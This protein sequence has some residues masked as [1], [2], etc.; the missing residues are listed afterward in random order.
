MSVRKKTY[1]FLALVV[2][3]ALTGYLALPY[4]SSGGA[5]SSADT[6]KEEAKKKEESSIPV[7]IAIA[8]KGAIS[9]SVGSTANLRPVRDVIV[10]AQTEGRVE[11][12]MVEEGDWVAKGQLLARLDD[13]QYQIRLQTAKQKLAQAKLQ[14]EKARI[15]QDKSDVQVVNTREEL[16]RYQS[17]YSERLVSEREVAQI[18]YRMDELLHDLRVSG[19]ESRELSHRVEELEAEIEQAELEIDRTRI[20]APF[21]GFITDRT[22]ERGQTIRN[23]D[24]LFKLGDFSPLIADVFLSER[25]ASEIA[26]GQLATL[27]SGVAEESIVG[28]VARISPVV[29]QS[30]GTV[31]VTVEVTQPG[32]LF[33]PGAFVRVEIQ[34]DTRQDSVLVPKRAVVEEDGEKYLFV[35]NET[36]AH[37]IKVNLGYEN[38]SDIEVLEGVA[39][40]D[41]VVVAG[42][43]ALK[44]GT[45]I[46]L[47]ES[48]ASA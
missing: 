4:L 5:V 43:G 37:K 11:E 32:R 48:G 23:M 38:G 40:G 41:A 22:V 28:Q 14:L 30:T 17:L 42:Q 2:V 3:F 10:A 45:S 19:S 35:T 31:K 20:E 34:T 12:V 7:E 27:S 39:P 6:E 29:D 15:L 33:K 46:K 44:E 1:G 26:P 8:R 47:V 9:S 18:R 24:G 13:S 21:A 25:E 16:D 36:S